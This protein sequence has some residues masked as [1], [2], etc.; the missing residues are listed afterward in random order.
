[1]PDHDSPLCK[2]AAAVLLWLLATA[3][4]VW[5]ETLP[6]SSAPMRWIGATHVSD[7]IFHFGAY[8]VLALIP[9]LGFRLRPGTVTALAMVPLGVALEFVQ[10]HIPG[11]SYEVADMIA[12][13]CGVAAGIAAAL[14]ARQANRA[15]E[16]AAG[17]ALKP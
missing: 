1:M 4:V 17:P 8:F 16:Q 9:V 10:I 3:V 2:P 7:K 15:S 13:T 5:G 6:G 11:R 12:N 14:A